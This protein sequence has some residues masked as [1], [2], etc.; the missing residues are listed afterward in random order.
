MKKSPLKIET[1]LQISNLLLP[2]LLI[3]RLGGRVKKLR[4]DKLDAENFALFSLKP[5]SNI[6]E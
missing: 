2:E 1:S 4:N 6:P 5:Y 3:C